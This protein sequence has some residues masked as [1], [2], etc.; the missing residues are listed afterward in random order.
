[1]ASRVCRKCS[2]A[3]IVNLRNGEWERHQ[4]RHKNASRERNS[5]TVEWERLKRQVRDRD[6][7]CVMCGRSLA[8]LKRLGISIDTD[9]IDGDSQ[10]DRLSN[11]RVLCRP[12][13]AT[14][15]NFGRA[16]YAL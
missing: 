3:V 1:M 8:T 12:C 13:H 9:H 4:Q 6:G 14:T 7:G 11:L 16:K 15:P 5:G 2:P 10:N